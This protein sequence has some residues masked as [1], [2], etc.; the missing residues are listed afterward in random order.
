MTEQIEA[1]TGTDERQATVK[2][3]NAAKGWGFLKPDEPSALDVFVHIRAVEAAGWSTLAEGTRVSYEI[4][5]SRGR[6]QATMLRACATP[7]PLEPALGAV[8]T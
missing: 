1:A 2:F 6:P 4:E 5:M 3:F 8:T 7:A